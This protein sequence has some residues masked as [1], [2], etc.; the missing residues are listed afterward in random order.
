MICI[1]SLR[2]ASGWGAIPV[3]PWPGGFH[4][5]W[6]LVAI[7]KVHFLEKYNGRDNFVFHS[8]FPLV[9]HWTL[10]PDRSCT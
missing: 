3:F 9:D 4:G 1:V 2:V 6:F 8:S 5:P 7:S 10:P